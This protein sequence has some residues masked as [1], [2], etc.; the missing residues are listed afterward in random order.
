MKLT[1]Y[2]E[3]GPFLEKV[4]PVLEQNESANTLLLGTLLAWANS[5]E[6]K[7]T[8]YMGLVEDGPEIVLIAFMT[9]PFKLIL[10]GR[11]DES[12]ELVAENL[13]ANGW[14]V[15]GLMGKSDLTTAFAALWQARKGVNVRQ[16]IRQGLYGLTEVLPPQNVAG[17]FRQAQEGDVELLARWVEAF[18]EEALGTVFRGDAARDIR[19]RVEYG[20][21]FVWEDAAG[22]V[23]TMAG[24]ARPTWHG[25]TVNAVYTPPEQ[26]GK[27]YAS[28]CVAALSQRILD[29]GCRFATLF[30]DLANPTANSIYQ[31]IG[32]KHI[33]DYDELIF[34]A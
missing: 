33:T 6:P 14:E 34:E 27:G 13:A 28:A 24:R 15:S 26:R 3:A 21:L 10:Q 2:N 1:V 5:A 29:S 11:P 18:H 30:T 9:P 12:L 4:R 8:A 7:R 31:K 25:A 19:L 23:V 16:D 17:K 20:Q 22:Q 32:Y